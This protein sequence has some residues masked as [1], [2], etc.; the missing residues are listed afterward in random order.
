MN[1]K[2]SAFLSHCIEPLLPS[3]SGES[4]TNCQ[5]QSP[6]S[7]APWWLV[8]G[9]LMASLG[10]GHRAAGSLD[11]GILDGIGHIQAGMAILTG[12]Y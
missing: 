1:G 2:V 3:A 6:I 10:K 11:W 8:P 12:G 9:G 4:Q 5:G 7:R